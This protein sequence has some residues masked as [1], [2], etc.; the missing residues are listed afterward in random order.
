MALKF[1]ILHARIRKQFSKP[2][3][4]PYAQ[5]KNVGLVIN[6]PISSDL[7][8]LV[9]DFSNR[10]RNDGKT[11]ENILI[12]PKKKPE[13]EAD[14]GNHFQHKLIDNK[15]VNAAGLPKSEN[16]KSI[17]TETYDFLVFC[18]PKLDF[19][20]ICMA[21]LSKSLCKVGPASFSQKYLNLV[22]ANS[23]IDAEY[24]NNIYSTLNQIR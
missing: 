16:L 23:S 10:L 1:S 21:G 11:T 6:E 3:L 22:I 4:V 9:S 7:D 8:Q 24:F 14:S 20:N 5:A 2:Q 18:N 17:L 15:D 12:F 19:K 13:N